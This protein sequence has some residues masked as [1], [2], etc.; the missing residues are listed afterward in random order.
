MSG[1]IKFEKKCN[2]PCDNWYEK[3]GLIVTFIIP[4][5]NKCGRNIK[6]GKE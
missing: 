3:P 2:V 4:R 6:G 1:R 5:C